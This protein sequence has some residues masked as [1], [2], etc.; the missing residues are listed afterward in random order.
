MDRI[1][2]VH[3]GGTVTVNDN[4]VKYVGVE[5]TVLV[6]G[7]CSS[8]DELVESVK[9]KLG[10]TEHG[11]GV[12]FEGRYDIG[13]GGRSLLMLSITLELEWDTYMEVVDLSQLKSIDQV[14]VKVM[15]F[16]TC[17]GTFDLNHPPM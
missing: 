17:E 10:W 11:V 12:R 4:G 9:S 13:V 8:F 5:L 1:V 6:Y 16:E 2:C 7:A 14:V 3:H 15:D